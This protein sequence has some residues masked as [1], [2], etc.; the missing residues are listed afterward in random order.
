[1]KEYTKEFD[2]VTYT[3]TEGDLSEPFSTVLTEMKEDILKSKEMMGT[4]YTGEVEDEVQRLLDS[5]IT[6]SF[7]FQVELQNLILEWSKEVTPQN[8]LHK[9]KS[10]GSFAEH[11]RI[12]CKDL[13]FF[14]ADRLRGLGFPIRKQLF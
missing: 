3:F 4:R 13:H 1:M 12:Y 10:I 8:S 2:G 14:I 7:K 6:S 11:S 9:G 5:Y